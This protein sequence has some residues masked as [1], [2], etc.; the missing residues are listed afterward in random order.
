MTQLPLPVLLPLFLLFLLPSPYLSS[1]TPEIRYHSKFT[2]LTWQ[3]ID[4]SRISAVS[5]QVPYV[6]LSSLVYKSLGFKCDVLRSVVRAKA[7]LWQ[8]GAEI[9]QAGIRAKVGLL[10]VGKT[11][12]SNAV[13][14]KLASAGAVAGAGAKLA[15]A[16]VRLVPVIT[17]GKEYLSGG[18]CKGSGG[19]RS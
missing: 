15:R 14:A 4:D 2:V 17:C 12:A 8:A 18:T 11:L 5:F 16:K 7:G 9:G 6:D 3:P 10:R 19:R 13:Q 1:P